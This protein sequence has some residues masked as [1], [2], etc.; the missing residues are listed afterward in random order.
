MNSLVSLILSN[1]RGPTWPTVP[2][3]PRNS[4]LSGVLVCGA[5]T[6]CPATGSTIPG[7]GFGLRSRSKAPSPRP[8]GSRS[9]SSR[10]AAHADEPV[11]LL[12]HGRAQA[13]RGAVSVA[14]NK[15]RS[16]THILPYISAPIPTTPP[17]GLSSARASLP[18]SPPGLLG[19]EEASSSSLVPNVRLWRA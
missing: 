17:A 9:S 2:Q 16:Y 14:C 3:I 18:G 15:Q 10:L 12:H 8:V 11:Q 7:I 1:L 13:A 6:A 4:S 19:A 5:V